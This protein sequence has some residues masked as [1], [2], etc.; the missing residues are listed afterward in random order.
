MFAGVIGRSAYWI[1][2][3]HPRH[4]NQQTDFTSHL[5]AAV[6]GAVVEVGVWFASYFYGCIVCFPVIL[7]AE[8]GVLLVSGYLLLDIL[9]RCGRLQLQAWWE[10]EI[11]LLPMLHMV[12]LLSLHGRLCCLS[13]VLPSLPQVSPSLMWDCP[14][15]LSGWLVVLCLWLGGI[16]MVCVLLCS[17]SEGKLCIISH[18]LCTVGPISVFMAALPLFYFSTWRQSEQLIS[19]P[20][21]VK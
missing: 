1:V 2:Y 15:G 16:L 10:V 6:G 8:L 9:L 5:P 18:F 13:L 19:P 12:L 4:L 11:M 17:C 7:F 3:W 20:L 14:F 21:P